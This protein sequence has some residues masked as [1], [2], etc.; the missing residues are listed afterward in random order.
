MGWHCA[1]VGG[2]EPG[3]AKVR[4]NRKELGVGRIHLGFFTYLSSFPLISSRKKNH[5]KAPT[6]L[7][8]KPCAGAVSARLVASDVSAPSIPSFLGV[9]SD[10]SK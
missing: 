1:L 6:A 10:T 2:R 4:Q 7:W 8:S 3:L 9:G 5:G